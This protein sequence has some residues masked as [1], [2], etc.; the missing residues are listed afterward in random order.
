VSDYGKHLSEVCG[1]HRELPADQQRIQGRERDR[2]VEGVKRRLEEQRD[3]I[4]RLEGRL[5]GA[6]RRRAALIRKLGEAG[7][8]ERAIA[9]LAGVSNV[10]VHNVLRGRNVPQG[11]STPTQHEETP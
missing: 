7:L 4:N 11:L 10:T 8:S 9:P 6:R 3:E 5:T 1:R 2:R